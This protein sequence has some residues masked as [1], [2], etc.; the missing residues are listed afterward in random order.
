MFNL[1]HNPDYNTAK[2]V[3]KVEKIRSCFNSI[4]DVKDPMFAL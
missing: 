3:L 2:I 1:K 4:R